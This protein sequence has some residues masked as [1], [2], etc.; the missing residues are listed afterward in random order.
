MS[1][2]NN[3]VLDLDELLTSDNTE[4]FA[5]EEFSEF[6]ESMG[7][8]S[9]ELLKT[10]YQLFVACD[11]EQEAVKVLRE[12]DG[13]EAM[14]GEDQSTWKAKLET[15]LEIEEGTEGM[16]TQDFWRWGPVGLLVGIY[17]ASFNRIASRIPI[18][19]DYLARGKSLE[20]RKSLY[21]GKA[22]YTIALIKELVEAQ[23]IL[24]NLELSNPDKFDLVDLKLKVRR[25]GISLGN[26]PENK[27]EW[28]VVGGTLL[29]HLI[30]TAPTAGLGMIVAT[31][32][33]NIFSKNVGSLGSRGWTDQSIRT[34]MQDTLALVVTHQ[35]HVG[36]IKANEKLISR[37]DY[38]PQRSA[39]LK[40]IHYLMKRIIKGY[41]LGLSRVGRGFASIGRV[42]H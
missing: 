41:A 18:H 6:C 19:L 17:W 35:K 9:K 2:K 15:F 37:T 11:N 39:E 23:K 42:N 8:C 21:L 33:G 10:V 7:D 16:K 27:T 22:T 4:F 38:T 28:K 5:N 3:E 26:T 24:F 20:K 31:R 1:E 29:G 34:A 32:I 12:V 25:L 13:F 36:K 30:L 14:F 40:T